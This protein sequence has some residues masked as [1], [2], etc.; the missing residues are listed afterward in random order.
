VIAVLNTAQKRTTLPIVA[1]V[2]AVTSS[3]ASGVPVISVISVSDSDLNFTILNLPVFVF[4][5][6][7][8]QTAPDQAVFSEATR[9]T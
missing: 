1:P 3:S 5:S 4:L 8:R 2:A 6:A 9:Q 7:Y